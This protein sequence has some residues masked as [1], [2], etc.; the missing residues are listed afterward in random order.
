[1][2]A[3]GT[4]YCTLGPHHVKRKNRGFAQIL[5]AISSVRNPFYWPHG[6]S[7]ADAP[8]LDAGGR[9]CSCGFDSHCGHF[10]YHTGCPG[11]SA[12]SDSGGFSFFTGVLYVSRLPSAAL[13]TAAIRAPSSMW[14]VPH[15]NS[16]SLTYR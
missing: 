10:P 3:L 6:G 15:R 12:T 8:A 1:M 13:I 14:R 4:S 5:H 11:V 2:I 7:T 16:N 9:E